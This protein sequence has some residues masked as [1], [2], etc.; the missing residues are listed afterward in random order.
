MKGEKGKVQDQRNFILFHPSLTTQTSNNR[1]FILVHLTRRF[2][3]V[4]ALRAPGEDI[5]VPQRVTGDPNKER[6]GGTRHK[7]THP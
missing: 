1:M 4:G 6:Q 2:D 3:S 7:G 5:S